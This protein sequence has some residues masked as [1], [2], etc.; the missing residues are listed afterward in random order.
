MY[1][2]TLQSLVNRAA[3]SCSRRILS[4]PVFQQLFDGISEEGKLVRAGHGVYITPD[5]MEDKMF[6]LQSEKRLIYSHD[7]PVPARP[8]RP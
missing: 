3:E 2:E 5:A 4:A 8:D 1:P 7:T 6:I